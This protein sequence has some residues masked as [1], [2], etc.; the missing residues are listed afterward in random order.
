MPFYFRME[1]L[2]HKMQIKGNCDL[3]INSGTKLFL[4]LPGITILDEKE[5]LFFFQPTKRWAKMFRTFL[6]GT[7]NGIT[8]YF[9]K[10]A[11]QEQIII[12]NRTVL[13]NSCALAQV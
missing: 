2:L 3:T 13:G 10:K 9:T 5:I 7:S 11:I 1:N 8:L 12:P 4:R 6:I